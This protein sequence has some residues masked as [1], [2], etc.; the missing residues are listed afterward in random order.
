[1]AGGPA[2]SIPLAVITALP[3]LGRV[4]VRSGIGRLPEE[5]GF[6]EQLEGAV[7]NERLASDSARRLQPS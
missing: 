7:P 1:V 6:P 3:A 5:G 4:L 2:L